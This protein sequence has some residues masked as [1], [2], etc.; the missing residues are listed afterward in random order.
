MVL[1]IL[2]VR[3]IASYLKS[4]QFVTNR[5]IVAMCKL[6]ST[7]V[8]DDHNLDYYACV[9]Y[10]EGKI[11]FQNILPQLNTARIMRH[12]VADTA[13]DGDGELSAQMIAGFLQAAESTERQ[14]ENA[15]RDF[16]VIV[17]LL[18]GRDINFLGD[19][20]NPVRNDQ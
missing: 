14:L 19:F 1:N 8:F 10:V 20:S 6:I 4:G 9:E 15:Y 16:A 2:T 13:P 5:S 18:R 12:G 17:S 11:N 3:A 7:K